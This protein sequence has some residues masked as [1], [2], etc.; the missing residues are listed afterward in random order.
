MRPEFITNDPVMKDLYKKIEKV[1]N[2][3]ATV[4]ITGESGT[5][6]EVVSRLIHHKSKRT[7]K[8]FIA[9]NCAAI[10]RDMIESEL[11]GHEKGSFTGALQQKKGCFELAHKGTLFLDEIA[12]MDVDTQVKL[13]RAVEYKS[14]RRLGG[15]E[16]VETDARIVAATNKEM[17]EALNNGEFRED[18]FYRLSVI[19]LHIP[20]LRER[21]IDI[22]L[23][24]NHFLKKFSAKYNS[25]QK[26]FS[27]ECLEMLTEYEWP[28]NVREL[29]NVVEKCVIL[30]PQTV[31]SRQHLSEE[32][33]KKSITK[34]NPYNGG[35]PSLSN[36]QINLSVGL[37]MEEVEKIF[38]DK[39]LLSVD[40]NKSKAAKIL[41]VSRTT[42]H[43]KLDKYSS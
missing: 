31:I 42:L 23:L 38:I 9:L 27:E 21:E 26:E 24:A 25:L 1:A 43:N 3:E 20:P 12:E 36:Q 13:L 6:K 5:G 11:F 28:G 14:F 7:N 19:E 2:T 41:G 33:L 29:S 8:S 37:T 16:E 35:Y 10:P 22:P 39:T 17:Q 32:I 30:C 15:T 40:N 4:L 18:L 34:K